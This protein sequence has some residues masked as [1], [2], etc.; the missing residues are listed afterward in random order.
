M[1][2][3]K[4]PVVVQAKQYL[5]ENLNEIINFV[6][7]NNIIWKPISEELFIM[8]L[9]GGIKVS[10][11]DYVIK[12]TKGEFYPV[13]PYVFEEIYDKVCEVDKP[14]ELISSKDIMQISLQRSSGERLF[15]YIAPTLNSFD[16][17]TYK[18]HRLLKLLKI[19]HK[20][21]IE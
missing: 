19:E 11:Y 5:G 3:R 15:C 6:G 1:L 2:V 10:M 16:K 17:L 4:R 9:D 14:L 12:G 21:I 18:L 20:Q 13:K 8:T 7:V